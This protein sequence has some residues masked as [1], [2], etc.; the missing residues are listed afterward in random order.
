MRLL[1]EVEKK[2]RGDASKLGEE[3]EVNCLLGDQ[4]TALLIL[5]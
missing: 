3:I 4:L 2:K 5:S 1:A